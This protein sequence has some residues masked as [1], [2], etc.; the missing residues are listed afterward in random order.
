MPTLTPRRLRHFTITALAAAGVA[1]I[2]HA[3]EAALLHSAFTTGW[4]LLGMMFF[5]TLYNARKKLPFLPLGSSAAWMQLHLYVG[6]LTVFIFPMHVGW[7]IPNGIL[8]TALALLFITV[9][10]S[11]VLGAILSRIIPPRLSVRGE[12]V[13]FERIPA[14]TA[15]LRDEARRLAVESAAVSDAAT[16]SDFYAHRLSFFFEKPRHFPQHLLQ[17][18]RPRHALLEGLRDLDRYLSPEEREIA[19]KL[20]DLVCKKDDLDYHHAMQWLLKGWLFVHIGF[21]YALLMLAVAHAITVYA[22]A[23][24]VP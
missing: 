23:G 16:L 10:G 13:I 2:V 24:G 17:S 18:A 22:F 7:R 12:E 3:Q 5:L 6:L 11:G 9:A 4:L 15:K 19:R 21:T 1:W 14:F 20:S 8:E